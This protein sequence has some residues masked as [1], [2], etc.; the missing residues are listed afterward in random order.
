M[1]D[2]TSRAIESALQR[3]GSN[4]AGELAGLNE[5]LLARADREGLIDV[6]YATMDSPYGE[7]LVAA[8]N[9]G[10]V[11]LSLPAYT[12]E[13]ALEEVSAGISPRILEIPKRLDPVRRELDA[14]FEGKLTKFDSKVDWSLSRGFTGKVLHAVARIP[15]GKTLSYGQVAE[16]AGNPRAFRA[17]GTACSANPVPLIV[18]CHRVVQAGGKPGNYGGGPEM[19]LSLLEMEG[20]LPGRLG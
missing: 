1:T 5:R 20:A 4:H 7:L 3:A 11:K 19:K 9:R 15:Y 2:E 14:Y 6:A 12:Q 16:R 18:P 17:A 13:S 8:T 10:V